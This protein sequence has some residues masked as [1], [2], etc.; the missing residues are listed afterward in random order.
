MDKFTIIILI[1]ATIIVVPL[2]V[3]LVFRK[4]KIRS[5]KKELYKNEK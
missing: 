3:S 1:I 5:L 4:L 2:L